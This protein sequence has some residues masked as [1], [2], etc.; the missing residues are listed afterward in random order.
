[1][2]QVNQTTPG[3]TAGRLARRKARTR[4]AILAAASDLFRDQGFDET[5][6]QQ[7]ADAADTGTGTVYG[8]FSSKEEI[9]RAVLQAHAEEGRTRYLAAVTDQHSSLDRVLLAIQMLGSYA[10]L[11]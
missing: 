5:S 6:I 8:Y 10:Q 7:I 9:L 2:N 1:M 4:A 3:P 11:N